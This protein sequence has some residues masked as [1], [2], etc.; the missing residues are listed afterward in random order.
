[1][2]LFS[3]GFYCDLPTFGGFPPQ[4]DLLESHQDDQEGAYFQI[5]FFS[6]T[7]MYGEVCIIRVG[8]DSQVMLTS[9]FFETSLPEFFLQSLDD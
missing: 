4:F 3:M 5:V 2:H 8:V 9:L 1:M 6:H 7:H